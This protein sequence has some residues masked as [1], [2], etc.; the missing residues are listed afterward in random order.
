MAESTRLLKNGGT[1]ASAPIFVTVVR[2]ASTASER[3]TTPL[4]LHENN[5]HRLVYRILLEANGWCG[6]N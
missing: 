3:A 2:L 5:T 6:R 4:S 1:R